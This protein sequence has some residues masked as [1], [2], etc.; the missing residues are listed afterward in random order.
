MQTFKIDTVWKNPK[1]FIV[2]DNCDSINCISN[3]NCIDCNKHITDKNKGN[4]KKLVKEWLLEELAIKKR[5]YNI[6]GKD[7]L[8]LPVWC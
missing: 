4:P 1:H 5:E 7:F 8:N 3:I 6:S 2:C